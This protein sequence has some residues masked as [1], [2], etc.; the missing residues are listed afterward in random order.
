[1][2]ILQIIDSLNAGGAEKMAVNY[3]N[4]INKVT[5]FCAIVATRSEGDLKNQINSNV[6]YFFMNR[7][8][9]FDFKALSKLA[10]FVKEHKIEIVHAH[11]T[12]ALVA[13]MLKFK[14]PKL[15]IVWHDH[16]GNS[17]FLAQRPVKG[18]Q[19]L[20]RFFGGIISVNDAL[21][22]WSADNLKCK[23][24]IYLQNFP[25][26]VDNIKAETQLK[27]EAGKR[28][29]CLAN[30]R[31][32]KD[33]DFLLEIAK[34]LKA[35]YPDWTF[36]LIGKD[37]EDDYS[38]QIKKRIENE[39]LA[40]NVF[41]YGSCNDVAN[42]IKQSDIAILTS[43]SE[44]LPVA[45]LEYGYHKM[46]VVVT[47]VGEVGK[48]VNNRENGI[49]TENGD[50]ETFTNALEEIINNP[51]LKLQLAGGLK[52]TIDNHYTDVAVVNKYL[53]WIDKT[54]LK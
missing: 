2:R 28:I 27:G 39:S 3:A 48:V 7:K 31:P 21:L 4:V 46:P 30:L 47:N 1:M 37:F 38:A 23:N 24:A 29:V 40:N 26:F 49:I 36:H 14:M 5:G 9:K 52:V 18:Y 42:I 19:F 13:V 10:A 16:Y 20:S 12:S 50:V 44:G 22:K 51:A 6:P 53:G 34:K 41:I 45:L 11:S 8:G 54:V 17:E 25:N 43:R 33:H 15:K 32:Q 35:N